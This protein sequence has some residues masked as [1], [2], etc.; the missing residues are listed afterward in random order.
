MDWDKIE[1]TDEY[2]KAVD[3]LSKK[4]FKSR[5]LFMSGKPGVGKSV[6]IK[7]ITEVMRQQRKNI[8]KVAFTGAASLAVGGKTINS[9]FSIRVGIHDPFD[10]KYVGKNAKVMAKADLIVIEEAS[11][12]RADMLDEISTKLKMACGNNLPF[13]GKNILLAGD[14]FQV[15][16]I[17]VKEEEKIY[18][19]LGYD[20]PFFFGSKELQENGYSVVVLD[21]IYRQKDYQLKKVLNDIRVGENLEEALNYLNE[22]CYIDNIEESERKE[23]D[24]V[25][26]AVNRRADVI[27]HDRLVSLEGKEY[28]YEARIEGDFKGKVLS[29]ELLKLKVGAQVMI[30]KNDNEHDIYRNGDVCV[31]EQC[32][33]SSIK[34]RRK[35]DSK[36]ITIKR[37]IWESIEYKLE[38]GKIEEEVVGTYEQFP[39]MLC[40][41]FSVHKAQGMTLPSICID[42]DRKESFASGQVYVALTRMTKIRGE[43]GSNEGLTLN[44]KLY[45]SMIIVDE[46]V[47]DYYKNIEDKLI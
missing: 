11:M 32:G 34:V 36:Q 47:V 45:P 12:V 46:E 35:F 10:V 16:P 28:E 5:I 43:N 25:L 1:I 2:K 30:T 21:N 37:D 3:F 20:T 26:C 38:G 27:N 14:L 15:R 41:A 42:I 18:K 24:V 40:W 29:P 17:L 31:V 13:G 9:F 7:Y 4:T 6:F 44:K 39:L 23:R 19:M 22:N 8:V 33:L